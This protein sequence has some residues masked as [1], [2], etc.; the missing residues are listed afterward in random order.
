MA[1]SITNTGRVWVDYETA[2]AKHSQMWRHSPVVDAATLLS[3]IAE[4]YA[5]L[6]G[7]LYEINILGAR[8]A[9]LGSNVTL[10]IAWPGSASYGTGTEPLGLAPRFISWVGRSVTGARWSLQQYGLELQTPNQFRG[11][12]S[13]IPQLED[14]WEH[15]NDM[16]TEEVLVAIDGLAVKPYAYV[17]Y[18]YNDHWVGEARK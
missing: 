4:Y 11:E 2:N 3:G 13:S 5:F 6:S 17:N 1:H 9:V 18:N 8:Y 10:P 14:A 7:I 15:L 12:V 16:A